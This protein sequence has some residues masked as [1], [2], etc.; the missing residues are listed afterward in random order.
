M[1]AVRSCLVLRP[2]L[3]TSVVVAGRAAADLFCFLFFFWLKPVTK[4]SCREP[5]PG[6]QQEAAKIKPQ[7]GNLDKWHSLPGSLVNTDHLCSLP[8]Q[9]PVTRALLG[10][11]PSSLWLPQ[12]P[13]TTWP[14]SLTAELVLNCWRQACPF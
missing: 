9:M 5:G 3:V 7:R 4:L 10:S 8:V 14:P 13:V 12:T 2:Q 1:P 6:T 11:P